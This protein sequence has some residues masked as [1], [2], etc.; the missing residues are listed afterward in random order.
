MANRS[1][2]LHLSPHLG[3]RPPQDGHARAIRRLNR[4]HGPH[5]RQD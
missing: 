3:H 1:Q 4:S 5:A 2:L